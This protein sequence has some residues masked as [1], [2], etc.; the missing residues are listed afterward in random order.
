MSQG[1]ELTYEQ[2]QAI[3]HVKKYMDYEK[4]QGKS[5]STSNPARRTAQALNFSFSTVKN[6]LAD[7]NRNQGVVQQTERKPRGHGAPKVR[8]HE[9]TLVRRMIQDAYLRGEL[10]RIIHPSL[11]Q[12]RSCRKTGKHIGHEARNPCFPRSIRLT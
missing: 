1:K 12:R 2:K 11:F 10:A 7:A 6:V 5:V 4:G 3:V 9:I 8:G